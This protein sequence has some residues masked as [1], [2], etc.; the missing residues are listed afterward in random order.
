MEHMTQ[1]QVFK[2]ADGLIFSHGLIGWSV[3]LDNALRRAGQ[4]DYE[5]K[6]LSFSRNLL[7]SRTYEGSLD[8]IRHEVAHALTQGHKHDRVWSAK[9]RQLGGNGKRC[10]DTETIVKPIPFL[11]KAVC[12]KHGH[13]G[14]RQRAPQSGKRYGCNKC[15]KNVAYKNLIWFKNG[16]LEVLPGQVAR[17][18]L[19]TL[20][21]F[22]KNFSELEED[23][24]SSV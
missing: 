6:T 4:C 20:S 16:Q 19:D 7:A 11:W 13:I 5:T 10:F 18:V 24:L 17:E 23:L 14:G 21:L 15:P 3:K 9:F 2:I 22:R 8:T 1:A 12:S